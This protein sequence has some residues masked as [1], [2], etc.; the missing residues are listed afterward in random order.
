M[1]RNESAEFNPFAINP[2]M[3]GGKLRA[4]TNSIFCAGASPEAEHHIAH[5]AQ[6]SVAVVEKQALPLKKPDDVQILNLGN[7]N[8]QGTGDAYR[9][10]IH[11]G[12]LEVKN[13]HADTV[14]SF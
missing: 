4:C 7:F 5:R 12:T 14:I 6:V 13:N 3:F 1:H 10:L 9:D 8:L 2:Q 11:D